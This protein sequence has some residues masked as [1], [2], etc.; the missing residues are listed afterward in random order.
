MVA[1]ARIQVQE[2]TSIKDDANNDKLS[3][4]I[5]MAQKQ[6]PKAFDAYREVLKK[7]P[8]ANHV[9][10]QMGESLKHFQSEEIVNL[11]LSSAQATS[12]SRF[13]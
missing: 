9:Y 5:Y 6:Y 3:A 12:S 1:Q 8:T 7:E 4:D 2:C 11:A 10:Y 13:D